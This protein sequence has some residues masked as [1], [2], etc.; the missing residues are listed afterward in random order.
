MKFKRT[1][2]ALLAAVL[3]VPAVGI[4]A[5]A[6]EDEAMKTELT[7]VKQRIDIP[8]EY[9]EFSY[10]TSTEGSGTRY[11]FTWEKKAPSADLSV[12]GEWV[13][14]TVGALDIRKK[15]H[16]NLLAVRENG[17]PSTAVTSDTLFG[18]NQTIFALGKW[19]DIQKCFRI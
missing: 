13:G 7:Y 10:R 4:Y 18:E 11:N 17:Q 19:K 15:Y 2:A 3:A 6:A 5:D 8:K 16:L 9:S 14:K 1:S 12:P